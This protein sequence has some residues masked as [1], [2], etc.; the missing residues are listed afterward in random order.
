MK[1]SG[2]LCVWLM[3]YSLVYG[4]I[5][6]SLDGIRPYEQSPYHRYQAEELLHGKLRLADSIDALQPGLVW[7]DG[8]VQ[9]VWGLGVGLWL[10]PFA[11]AWR[12]V[13]HQPFPDRIALG[14]A[15]AI[16]AFYSAATGLKLIRQG[17]RTLGLAVFWM[18]ALCPAL[19]TLA[20]ADQ[21]VFEETVLYSVI[22]SLAILISLIR[23]TTF[24]SRADYLVCC[25]LGSFA[26]WVRPTH[27]VYGIGA[28]LIASLVAWRRRHKITELIF[29]PSLW[30]AS[31]A[32]LA[33]TN[34][35]R[36]GSATEFGHHLTVSTGNMIYFTRFGNPSR[37]AS[38]FQ[39]A[40]EL[41]GL[42]FLANP[43]GAFAFSENL[44]IGQSPVIRWRRLDLSAFDLSYAIL[45]IITIAMALLWLK[46]QRRQMAF[47]Q[48]PQTALISG[49]LMWS[50]FSTLLLGC[51]YL[52]YPAVASR[53]LLDFAPAFTGF[54]LV[55]LIL[56]PSRWLKFAGPLLAVWLVYE[57]ISAKVPFTAP[58]DRSP[59]RLTLPHAHGMALRD[60]NGI[61]T[62][63]NFPSKTGIAGN[64]YGWDADGGIAANV[65]SL[66]VDRPEFIELHLS[67]RRSSN[68]VSARADSYRAQI[69]GRT[70]PLR[71]VVAENDGLKVTFMVPQ[72]IRKRQQDE[73]LFLCFSDR[74]DAAD[75]NSERF[76]YSVR[77]R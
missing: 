57:I 10:L 7:H 42:L 3:L 64:G 1:R 49:L 56:L 29:G 66:A 45:M 73:M 67:A 36:F 53:Y 28:I 77:W 76:L 72:N 75:R 37:D 13:D 19:W 62:T 60:F 18:V 15:F 14:L 5:M 2:Q 17:Q 50:G 25:A 54:A 24:T 65:M 16:L 61:Y 68:G 69:D 47:W 33:W 21:L 26:I 27:A 34:A 31:L 74:Y 55:V 39:A 22:L 12:L 63:D 46:R 35:A 38:L 20:R 32:L 70:L 51:F 48:Q 41:F 40:K 43:Q 8:E 4:T 23:A 9:H 30:L 6:L 44:F 11:A 52:Y 59:I 58:R 71:E